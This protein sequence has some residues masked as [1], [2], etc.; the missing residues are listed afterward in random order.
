MS[1]KNTSQLSRKTKVEN[2]KIKH[3]INAG[4]YPQAAEQFYPKATTKARTTCRLR[5][6]RVKVKPKLKT[7]SFRQKI[8]N[9]A[10]GSK[11]KAAI[12]DFLTRGFETTAR[13]RTNHGDVF[14]CQSVLHSFNHSACNL[15][16]KEVSIKRR[17]VQVPRR[18]LHQ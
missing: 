18:G 12:F 8:C 7:E 3:I 5:S 16:P 11:K 2:K 6:P 14:D 13:F 9:S 17:V 10:F 1:R 4:H 15:R